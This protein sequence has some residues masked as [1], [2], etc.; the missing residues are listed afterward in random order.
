MKRA[1]YRNIDRANAEI[2]RLRQLVTRIADQWEADAKQYETREKH[3]RT[4]LHTA[5]RCIKEMDGYGR[6]RPTS[7]SVETVLSAISTVLENR[8]P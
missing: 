6:P 5:G 4:V 8:T 7:P 2:V 1:L 3:L